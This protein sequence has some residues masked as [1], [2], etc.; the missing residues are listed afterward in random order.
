MSIVVSKIDDLSGRDDVCWCECPGSNSNVVAQFSESKN[1]SLF[2]LCRGSWIAVVRYAFLVVRSGS[3]PPANAPTRIIRFNKRWRFPFFFHVGCAHGVPSPSKQHTTNI[4]QPHKK[5]SNRCPTN[6]HYLHRRQH[7][8]HHCHTQQQQ[9]QQQSSHSYLDNNSNSNKCNQPWIT[10]QPSPTGSKYSTAAATSDKKW[11]MAPRQIIITHTMLR[12]NTRC[13]IISN[14][15]NNN[16]ITKTIPM[17]NYPHRYHQP[18][19]NNHIFHPSITVILRLP[20]YR[21]THFWTQTPPIRRHH[22]RL[23]P[24][25]PPLQSEVYHRWHRHHL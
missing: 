13:P 9:Q 19:S 23:P 7:Q 18:P 8:P 21:N 1:C 20:P 3:T 5:C 14:N 6:F 24:K 25:S 11:H 10:T 16:S 2:Q 12:N 4:I 17:H 22:H 15:N